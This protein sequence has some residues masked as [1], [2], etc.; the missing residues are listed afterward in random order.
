MDKKSK[1]AVVRARARK[2]QIIRKHAEQHLEA[3]E[4]A[5][6]QEREQFAQQLEASRRAT[7]EGAGEEAWSARTQM[8]RNRLTN[9]KRKSM[10]R[11]N[12]FAGTAGGGGMGR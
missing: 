7:Q 5:L 12:R 9:K 3:H 8:I 11:W 4:A 10:D 1:K 2:V 6:E